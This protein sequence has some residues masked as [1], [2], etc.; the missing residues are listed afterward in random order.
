MP[1]TD[2]SLILLTVEGEDYQATSNE[3]VDAY[4]SVRNATTI[5]DETDENIGIV[6]GDY[7]EAVLPDGTRV[8][9]E[10]FG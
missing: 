5:T 3:H 1:D 8:A 9:V 7:L 2:G 4:Q 10:I 6:Y